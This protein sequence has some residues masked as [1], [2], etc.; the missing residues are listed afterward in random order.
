V[1]WHVKLVASQPRANPDWAAAKTLARQEVMVPP[2]LEALNI[3]HMQYSTLHLQGTAGCIIL[4]IRAISPSF[5]ERRDG[6]GAYSCGA[7]GCKAED[8]SFEQSVA[9]ASP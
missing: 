4:F 1:E 6:I 5:S 2:L 9:S 3:Q 7:R 8:G